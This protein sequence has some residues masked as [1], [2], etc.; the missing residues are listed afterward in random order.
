MRIG[1]DL[2]NT[3]IDYELAFREAALSLGWLPA[4]AGAGKTALR[5]ALRGQPGGEAR[6]A[7]LQARVYGPEIERARPF[8]GVAEFLDAARA[9]GAA[10]AI[11]SHKSRFAAAAPD[12]PDL[13][14][15][16]DRW[17]RANGLV[18]QEG[19]PVFYE[20]TRA[21]KCARIAALALDAFVD[22]LPEVFGEPCFPVSVRRVLFAPHGAAPGA[23]DLV[24]TSWH[25]LR[26]ALLA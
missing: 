13:R 9:A 17:L 5:D 12:G 6:W 19:P 15:C 25:E 7:A 20:D 21:D 18:S 3:I 2:D 26:A 14:A 23:A 4:D 1:I 24:V 16:A 22:D 11:V 8:P 10:I